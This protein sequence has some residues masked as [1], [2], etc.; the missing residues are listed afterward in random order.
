MS[1]D[2]LTKIRSTMQRVCA[3][4]ATI[5]TAGTFRL[6]PALTL[7]DQPMLKASA[8]IAISMTTISLRDA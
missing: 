5:S 1:I 7:T 2:A 8:K 4:I 3:I 6:M